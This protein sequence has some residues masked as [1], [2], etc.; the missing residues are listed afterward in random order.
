MVVG[1]GDNA[2]GALILAAGGG[3]DAVVI[4]DG[5]WSE[6][7]EPDDAITEMYAGLRAILADEGATRPPPSSGLDPRAKHGYGVHMSPSFAQRFWGAVTC[8]V[9]AIETPASSTPPGEREERVSWFG[10]EA[11]LLELEVTEPRV[12]LR[13]V[14]AWLPA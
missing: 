12:V 5:L 4:I 8:P 11:T 3:C 7:Q 14:E 9:L 1:V 2:H 13:A 10:G 6:W